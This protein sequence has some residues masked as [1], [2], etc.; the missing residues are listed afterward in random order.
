MKHTKSLNLYRVSQ[1][2]PYIEYIMIGDTFKSKN[3]GIC[4][5]LL[6]SDESVLYLQYDTAFSNTYFVFA[7]R[8]GAEQSIVVR[9]VIIVRGFANRLL[10][11]EIPH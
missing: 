4:L 6:L 1:E 5:E 3:I 10:K 7:C 2:V 9:T 8:C 11:T